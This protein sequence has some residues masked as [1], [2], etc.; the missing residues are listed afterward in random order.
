MVSDRF[1]IVTGDSGELLKS[2][3]VDQNGRHDPPESS[4]TVS[5]NTYLSLE[6]CFATISRN[7]GESCQRLDCRCGVFM[8]ARLTEGERESRESRAFEVVWM[9]LIAA[10]ELPCLTAPCHFL[11]F[12]DLPWGHALGCHI[13]VFDC[14]SIAFDRPKVEPTVCLDV[15][16]HDTIHFGVQASQAGLR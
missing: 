7:S 1:G 2:F 10:L 3:T 12:G 14:V 6:H 15:V 4:V 11:R 8:L 9:V 5:Q 16:P 13:A